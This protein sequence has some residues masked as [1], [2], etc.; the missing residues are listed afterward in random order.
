M[1]N[2]HLGDFYPNQNNIFYATNGYKF[3]VKINSDGFRAN[4]REVTCSKKILLL[5]DSQVF[6][7]GLSSEKTIS[8]KLQNKL[9]EN[10]FCYEVLNFGVMFF[11]IGD[12]YT[13]VKDKLS[14]LD[15]VEYVFVHFFS[16]NDLSDMVSNKGIFRHI[17]KVKEN[18]EVKLYLSTNRIYEY[19]KNNYPYLN[20]GYEKDN[21]LAQNSKNCINQPIDI[22]I[23]NAA[24][25]GD[26]HKKD[27]FELVENNLTNDYE[28][29]FK[30][31]LKGV[32]DI[33][34]LLNIGNDKY[35]FSHL[36][37]FRNYK[38]K[39]FDLDKDNYKFQYTDF[40][41]LFKN[42]ELKDLYLEYDW[43]LNDMATTIIANKYFE[44]II[45]IRR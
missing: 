23:F 11:T 1:S 41:E 8:S 31:Y 6:G 7:F 45:K 36:P 20:L 4:E 16:G 22:R 3:H 21:E 43:H 14:N 24:C 34:K 33:Q 29:L 18:Q 30:I 17:H 39:V 9:N 40:H 13:L 37:S 10:G 12:M 5:G 35:F 15:D 26:S 25:R 19:F 44:K 32:L 38:N 2:E 28:Y 42:R 27:F